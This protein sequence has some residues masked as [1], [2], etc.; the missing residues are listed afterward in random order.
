MVFTVTSSTWRNIHRARL[1]SFSEGFIGRFSF[2][3]SVW[4]LAVAGVLQL[5]EL[6]FE[7]DVVFIAQQLMKF[8]A[9][10][11]VGSFYSSAKLGRA[12]LDVYI[13]DT[14]VFD[15]PMERELE[16]AAIIGSDFSDPEWELVD[17]VIDK[18]DCASLGMLLVDLERADAGSVIN[19]GVL[20]LPDLR[21]LIFNEN[22]DFNVHL[23]M[24]AWGPFVIA[25][26]MDQPSL[27]VL[28]IGPF[29]SV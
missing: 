7:F 28:L 21:S 8:L 3:G 9:I 5:I 22:Q 29:P 2:E 11:T 18:V 20:E 23:D 25:P 13:A 24:M 10:G 17:D 6:G 26:G 19:G 27:T 16:L 4:F 1:K 12:G 15:M 14:E